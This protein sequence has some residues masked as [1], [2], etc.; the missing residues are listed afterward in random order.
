M[1]IPPVGHG[2]AGLA[3]YHEEQIWIQVE[4]H[5]ISDRTA[6]SARFLHHQLQPW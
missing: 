4:H 2:R 5:L 6:V 3:W 1:A